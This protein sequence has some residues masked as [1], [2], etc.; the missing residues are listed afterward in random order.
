MHTHLSFDT[1]P[2]LLAEIH[3]VQNA[4]LEMRKRSDTL[5]LNRVHVLKRMIEDPR[6]VDNLPPHVPVVEMPDK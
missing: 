1:V 4:R 6:R 5:H 2:T 3:K